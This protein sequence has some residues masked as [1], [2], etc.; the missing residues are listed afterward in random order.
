VAV[1]FAFSEMQSAQH[2]IS[3]KKQNENPT[4]TN[5][6]GNPSHNGEATQNFRALGELAMTRRILT[7]ASDDAQQIFELHT[8]RIALR[9]ADSSTALGILPRSCALGQP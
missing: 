9:M 8:S 3:P 1:V 4:V 2:R 6:Q 7:I 5:F